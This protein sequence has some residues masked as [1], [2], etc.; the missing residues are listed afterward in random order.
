MVR[1]MDKLILNRLSPG[2]RGRRERKW[3]AFWVFVMAISLTLIFVGLELWEIWA[4]V[5]CIA[6]VRWWTGR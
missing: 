2:P 5:L 4:L 1:P 6:W 3:P